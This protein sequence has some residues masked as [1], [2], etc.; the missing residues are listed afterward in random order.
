MVGSGSKRK[1]SITDQ[2]QSGSSTITEPERKH[3]KSAT[4]PD[5]SMKHITGDTTRDKCIQMVFGVLAT[6]V[7][8]EEDSEQILL[9]AIEIEQT[10]YEDQQKPPQ[11]NL[12][13]ASTSYKEL[14]FPSDPI[15]SYKSKIR[16]LVSNLKTN[17]SLHNQLV[18]SDIIPSEFA[19]MS[20]E[21]MMSLDRKK[22]VEQAYKDIM[23]DV[24]SATTLHAETV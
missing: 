21:D 13:D 23:L 8:D 15:S 6:G 3:G 1:Y 16:S 9:K 5:R 7:D 22:V 10:V 17:P 19:R 18:S 24:V 20:S 11:D 4:K 12:M 14:N 2:E